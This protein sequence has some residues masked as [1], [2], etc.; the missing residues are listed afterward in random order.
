MPRF[1]G[2]SPTA[3]A[4]FK[5]LRFHQD[6]EWFHENKALYEDEVKAPMLNLLEVLTEMFEKAGIPLRG[7]KRG[8]FRIHRDVRFSKDKRPYQTH[9]SAVLTPSGTKDDPGL[10]YVHISAN[11]LSSW[12]GGQD[13]SFMAAGFHQPDRDV[14][15]GVRAY[16]RKDPHRFLE[17]E[18]KLNKSKLKLGTSNQ[19]TRVPRGFEDMKGSAVESALRLKGLIV[20]A[21]LTEAVVTSP[22]LVDTIVKFA[23]RA[24]PV[25]DFGWEAIG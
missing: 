8:M 22:K 11:G 17:M 21:P 7:D 20:E 10:V 12:A 3:L 9:A 1:Q 2:F 24:R 23:Q 19:L 16:I 6:R 14:L 4:F 18:A 15:T 13:G 25:L 5:A